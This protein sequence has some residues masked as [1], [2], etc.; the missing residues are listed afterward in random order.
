MTSPL[1]GQFPRQWTLQNEMS[2]RHT[3][4]NDDKLP[5][6]LRVLAVL[7]DYLL[8]YGEIASKA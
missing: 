3:N 6:R 5:L 2:P 7:K 1:Y 4:L 8:E